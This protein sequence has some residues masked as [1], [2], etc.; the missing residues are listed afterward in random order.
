MH[1]ALGKKSLTLKSAVDDS[2]LVMIRALK[3]SSVLIAT[4]VTPNPVIIRITR[5][6]MNF[7]VIEF[8]LCK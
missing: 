8:A 1:D 3:Y 4:N 5:I 6:Q 7:K 2:I